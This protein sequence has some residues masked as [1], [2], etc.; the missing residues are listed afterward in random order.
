MYTHGEAP[1]QIGHRGPYVADGL[2]VQDEDIYK[3]AYLQVL[4]LPCLTIA[5]SQYHRLHNRV[6][7]D[8]GNPHR[9]ADGLAFQQKVE[10]E[11]HFVS[12]GY[13]RQE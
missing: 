9:G 5:N 6:A 11:N 3:K 1:G 10:S 13:I 4:Y 12:D 7:I 2:R 8:A